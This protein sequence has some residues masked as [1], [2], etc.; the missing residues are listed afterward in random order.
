MNQYKAMSDEYLRNIYVP[1]VYQKSIFNIDY[2]QLK[3][4]GIKLI[5]FD[6]DDTLVPIEKQKP[7]KAAITLI[8][9]L[10]LMGFEIYLVSN[11]NDDRVKEIF[12]S[13]KLQRL[14]MRC[15]MKK[16]DIIEK[17]PKL[18]VPDIGHSDVQIILKLVTILAACHLVNKADKVVT[19][20]NNLENPDTII[21]FLK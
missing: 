10:K 4:A 20:I 1:D 19:K 6:I 3:N 14:Q 16:F 11:A 13:T 21:R 9:Q 7:T 17:I 15:N 5:S 12:T 8:E 2:Q 18:P